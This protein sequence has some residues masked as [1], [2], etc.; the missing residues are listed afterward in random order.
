[1][2]QRGINTLNLTGLA[3]LLL[4]IIMVKVVAISVGISGPAGVA[5]SPSDQTPEAMVL[6]PTG[7]PVWAPSQRAAAER[8]AQLRGRPFAANPLL[9]GGH[10]TPTTAEQQSPANV[11]IV[12][13][14]LA[15]RGGNVAL[16]NNGQYRVGDRLVGSE[17]LITAI[18]SDARIVIVQHEQN[19]RE[20]IL[21]V[22]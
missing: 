19:G 15:T 13:V 10:T 1:V 22:Q 21:R 5:A 8:A 17:Y 20:F 3:M 12:Q 9:Y 14:I 2:T 11:Y 7:A 16:I 18:D 6:G 4:P